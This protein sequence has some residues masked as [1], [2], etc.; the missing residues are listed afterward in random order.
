MPPCPTPSEIAHAAGPELLEQLRRLSRGELSAEQ[1]AAM[2]S[3]AAPPAG[4]EAEAESGH[5]ALSGATVDLDRQR[6]CG[7]GE[8]IYGEGKSAELITEIIQSQLD[9]KQD[10]L[11]TRVDPTTAAQVRRHFEH[12]IHH[13]SAQ[14]LRIGHTNCEPSL[15]IKGEQPSQVKHVS[16]ITAGSTD[17]NV[18]DEAVETLTWMG[19][20]HQRFNDMGVAG[21]SRLLSIVPELR[22]SEAVIVVA[23]MEGALASVVGGHV[24]VPVFAVPTSVGYGANLGGMTPL[25]GMLSSCAANVA[26]VNVDAGFKGGYLAGLVVS[27]IRHAC[28][29]E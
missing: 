1:V 29:R 2:I 21:P 27:R 10:A 5:F 3:P 18:A 14:T 8:V 28:D 16:V 22:T 25:M 24:A 15:P 4:S 13:P 6:R 23:G 19:I 12:V 26:V 7:F 9:V 20:P 17:A 11:V